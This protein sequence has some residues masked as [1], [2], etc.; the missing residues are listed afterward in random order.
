VRCSKRD[1]NQVLRIFRRQA[2]NSKFPNHWNGILIICSI[3]RF[4]ALA[5]KASDQTSV[6]KDDSGLRAV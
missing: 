3:N 2:R 1:V 6:L 4:G 5:C